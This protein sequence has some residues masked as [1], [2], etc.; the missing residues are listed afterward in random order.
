MLAG[1]ERGGHV[2]Q[3]VLDGL[4]A[5]DGPAELLAVLG[6]VHRQR[7]GLPGQP[8]HRGAMQQAVHADAV[9]GDLE[10]L[11]RFADQVLLGHPHVVEDDVGID[12]LPG[13]G[14]AVM[15]QAHA[16]AVQVDQNSGDAIRAQGRIRDAHGDGKVREHGRRDVVLGARHDVVVA[17]FHGTG[18][19]PGRVG[20]RLRLRHRKAGAALGLDHR[21][22]VAL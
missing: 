14:Y 4:E 10:A 2:G 1:V 8:D 17:V 6:I 21:H 7:V 5:A 20:T 3:H 13:H 16:G 22:D 9:H 12:V 11:A 19:Q 18:F 15:H